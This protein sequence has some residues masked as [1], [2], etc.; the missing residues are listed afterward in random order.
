MS[1]S[2]CWRIKVSFVRQFNLC[3]I[4]LQAIDARFTFAYLDRAQSNREQFKFSE[5][6]RK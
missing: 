4:Y 2:G 1:G 6:D 5:G 3:A